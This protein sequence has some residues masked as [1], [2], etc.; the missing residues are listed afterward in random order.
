MP[1]VPWGDELALLD[2]D[3]PPAQSRGHH[4]IRLP[5]QECRNLQHIHDLGNF[6]HIRSFMHV[7]EHG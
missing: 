5:A 4:Q 1:H 3:G 7:G 6:A 2:V